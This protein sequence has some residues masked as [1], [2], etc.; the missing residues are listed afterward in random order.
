VAPGRLNRRTFLAGAIA[1]A[2]AGCSDSSPTPASPTASSGPSS[3][4]IAGPTIPP[5]TVPAGGGSGV[6][7]PPATGVAGNPFSLGVASGDPLPDRVVLWTRLAPL[8]GPM[9]QAAIGVRWEIATDAAFEKRL[10]EGLVPAV[11]QFG[12]SVHVDVQGLK[13]ATTY[14]YRFSAG[15]WTSPIGRT[16]TAPA[17]GAPVDRLKLAF[18]SCQHFEEGFYRAWADA[19][20]SDLDLVIHLGD[21]IYE[22][23]LLGAGKVRNHVGGAPVTLEQYRARWAQYK[24]DK[25]LQAAHAAC[26]WLVIW[27]DH[28]VENNYAATTSE[29]E[30]RPGGPSR[31]QFLAQRA[32]AY[33]A[34][35]EHQPVRLDPPGSGEFRIYRSFVWGSLATLVLTDSR[36]YRTDQACG[37]VPLQTGPACAEAAEPSRT[38]WGPEQE[39]W[40]LDTLGTATTTWKA[41]ANEVVMGDLRLPNGG[42]LNYDQWDGYAPARNRFLGAV[43]DRNV[44]NLVVLT[45]D[46]HLAGAIDLSV[47]RGGARTVVASELVGTS[48]SSRGLLPASIAALARTLFPAVKYFNGDKRGY[49]RCT[50]TPATWTCEYRVVDDVTRPDGTVS[51]DAT[52]AIT[53]G[54]PGV[55]RR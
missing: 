52:V 30:G 46:I 39:R 9:P 48:I 50:V 16:R 53:A 55:V 13:P 7:T 42:I 27:D 25:D 23:E 14:W 49:A 3:T 10:Y 43:A 8:E 29:R 47:D 51:T 45:G 35:W 20:A 34:W 11:P 54:T 22:D 40:V 6:A 12:H 31:E 38:M 17:V 2:A 41:L 4:G 28:E 18:A 44:T 24:G 26:P 37:D 33:Q 32:A 36:Q 19:A 5:P 1:V 21:Y 15:S